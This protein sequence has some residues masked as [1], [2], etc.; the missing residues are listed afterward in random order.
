MGRGLPALRTDKNGRGGCRA[1]PYSAAVARA[2]ADPRAE[3]LACAAPPVLLFTARAPEL[4]APC[5]LFDS[6]KSEMRGTI[7]ERKRDP[8]NTP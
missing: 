7:S 8:L 6:T 3:P 2:V 1:L 4:R 5:V